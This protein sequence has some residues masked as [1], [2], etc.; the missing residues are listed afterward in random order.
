MCII[1]QIWS[2]KVCDAI[3]LC[4]MD[5]LW[6]KHTVE[7]NNLQLVEEQKPLLGAAGQHAPR[8]LYTQILQKCP[9]ADQEA[10][11]HYQPPQPVIRAVREICRVL[12]NQRPLCQRQSEAGQSPVPSSDGVAKA[13]QHEKSDP[14]EDEADEKCG[15]KHDVGAQ[16]SV[17]TAYLV[18]ARLN[19][20]ESHVT[21]LV[22]HRC[23]HRMV[24]GGWGR[25]IQH[26]WNR[27]LVVENFLHLNFLI[28]RQLA[29]CVTADLIDG[30]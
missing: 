22:W 28:S 11:S 29:V 4:S 3:L 16:Q 20:N 5:N 10:E 19:R 18:I 12:N 27:Q 7:C 26:L 14:I 2:V 13:S 23:T 15:D 24:D 17:I 25:R 21:L 1:T 8:L 30:G 6:Q 9:N